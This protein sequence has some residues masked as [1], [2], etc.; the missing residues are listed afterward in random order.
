MNWGC[1]YTS[2]VIQC[3]TQGP[4]GA[5]CLQSKRYLKCTD[6][7]DYQME[8]IERRGLRTIKVGKIS[9]TTRLN[10][11]TKIY[12]VRHGDRWERDR[13]ENDEKWSKWSWECTWGH[14]Y[15]KKIAPLCK[16]NQCFV[17]RDDRLLRFQFLRFW[18]IDR[19]EDEIYFAAYPPYTYSHSLRALEHLRASQAPRVWCHI[20]F[21]FH[22]FFQ[23]PR[24]WGP[25]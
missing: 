12:H 11:N 10:Q 25:P 20:F 8:N 4:S 13:R 17:A 6:Y 22:M 5:L 24:V 7:V 23:A 19:K 2:M 14:S 3:H 16:R 21:I 1:E 15:S 18:G 9:A